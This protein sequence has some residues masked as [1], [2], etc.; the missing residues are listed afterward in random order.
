MTT[1]AKPPDEIAWDQ[2]RV[3]Y[4][5]GAES[6]KAI[7]VDAGLEPIRLSMKAKALGWLLRTRNKTATKTRQSKSE[8]TRATIKRLKDLLQNRIAQ[9][10]NQISNLGADISALET[11][12]EIRATNT[13]VR[14]LEKVI[15]LERKDRNRNS[16]QSDDFKRFNEAERE[17]LADKLEK[18][19]REWR[20]EKIAA[21]T[22][23]QR[24]LQPQHGVA[25]LGEGG[26]ATAA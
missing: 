17:A 13:L 12:R 25:V 22:D 19:D 8:S 11:E 23:D 15:E 7:A 10:E 21:A 14:T 24:T 6:I 26:P 9:I 4:E 2:I 5:T 3:R 18:L 1:D 16:R 20:A